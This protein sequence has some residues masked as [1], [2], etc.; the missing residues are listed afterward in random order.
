MKFH[1]TTK[2]ALALMI[3]LS[4]SAHSLTQKNEVQT[5]EQLSNMDSSFVSETQK[6]IDTDNETA[7][8]YKAIERQYFVK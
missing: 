6:L 5:L 4:S 1:G 8:R 2:A 3:L 7:Q